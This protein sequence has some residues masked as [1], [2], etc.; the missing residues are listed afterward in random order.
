MLVRFWGTRGSLPVALN[1][2]ALRGKFA[3][4]IER[5]LASGVAGDRRSIESFIDNELSFAQRATYGGNSSCVEIAGG[6]T[7]EFI[8]CDAGSGLREFGAHV[9]EK[10][11]PKGAVINILLSHPHWDHIM[12]FPFFAPAYLPGNTVRIFGC[13]D[14]IE[15]VLRTQNSAPYFPVS[16][17]TMGANIEFHSLT[18][19][20]SAT[21]AGLQ[22]TPAL[23]RHGGDSFGYRFE[24]A[25]GCVVYSTDGEH[26]LER[27]AELEAV[28]A[29]FK[30]ADLVIFDAMYS[31]ADA[32]SV[33]EDWGHSSN[34]VGVDLCLRA[35]VGHYCMFHHEPMNDDATLD[36]VLAETRRYEELSRDDRRLHVSSA[37]DGLEIHI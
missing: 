10:R 6:P 9:I 21:I 27:A 1:A 8:V 30:D 17:D 24:H 3:D 35:G 12:G 16:F 14:S 31:L 15:S 32:I 2:Q 18:P 33:R 5:A 7:S 28:V 4:A 19:G 26:K 36:R 23:Q 20:R 25:D 37:Y 22:V 11:G 34:L 29:F 13:H